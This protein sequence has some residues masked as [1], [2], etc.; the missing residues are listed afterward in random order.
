V[1]GSNL[2]A[3]DEPAIWTTKWYSNP[4]LFSFKEESTGRF[5]KMDDQL[6]IQTNPHDYSWERWNVY[7][8]SD[9]LSWC[10]RSYSFRNS[11][12]RV[13]KDGTNFTPIRAGHCQTEEKF[14]FI[15]LVEAN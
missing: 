5:L 6:K 9:D 10:I 11:W 12:A 1:S 4:G 3:S 15:H 8:A 2:V 7:R 14:R 13:R